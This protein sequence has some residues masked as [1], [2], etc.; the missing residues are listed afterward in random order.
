[1]QPVAH[2]S[3]RGEDAAPQDEVEGGARR[4]AVPCGNMSPKCNAVAN[5]RAHCCN[6]S[7]INLQCSHTSLTIMH[8]IPGERRS[9][10]M[11]VNALGGHHATSL[12]CDPR[13]Q[14]P[15]R[16]RFLHRDGARAEPRRQRGRGAASL[17]RRRDA[18]L[19]I[20]N[21]RP[22]AD[23]R[24]HAAATRQPERRLPQRVRQVELAIGIGK[25]F[26]DDCCSAIAR[27]ARFRSGT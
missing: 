12:A 24:V 19:L 20:G 6:R 10:W 18:A 9:A 4:L 23:H 8:A 21:S 26:D 22:R 14:N 3:R 13:S 1:M 11:T 7:A 16:C 5:C 25:A 15:F 2:P 17:H 27:A